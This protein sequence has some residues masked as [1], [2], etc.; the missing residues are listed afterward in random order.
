[1][2]GSPVELDIVPVLSAGKHRNPSKGACFM[3]FAS[4]LAGE[5]WSDH[6][7]CT[8]AALAHLA[9]MVNDCSTNEGR[10][11]LAPLI[12]SVIGLTTDD[13][14][15]DA[16]IAVRAASAALAVAAEE[17]QHALAVG[18]IVSMRSLERMGGAG[19]IDVERPVRAA[20]AAAPSA[21]RWAHTFMSAHLVREPST[22]STRQAHSIIASS[23]DGIACAC[24]QDADE[25]LY[26]LLSGAIQDCVA[27]LSQPPQATTRPAA[28]R[29]V[30]EAGSPELSASR[31]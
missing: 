5:K 11:R 1:M 19:P 4:Y 24:V 18:A 12:P 26:Q 22:V 13:P 29:M 31:V 7:A 9:R 28:A 10:S 30:H 6:P 15:L 17:R 25:R 27:F 23:V 3:E 8:H 21:E 20:F 16:I 14:R 2:N